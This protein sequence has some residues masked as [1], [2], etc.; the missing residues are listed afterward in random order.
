MSNV[1]MSGV[2][3]ISV[4]RIPREK[5]NLYGPEFLCFSDGFAAHYGKG[6][7]G[8]IVPPDQTAGSSRGVE[9]EFFAS[10]AVDNVGVVAAGD[11]IHR[12]SGPR[13]TNAQRRGGPGFDDRAYHPAIA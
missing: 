13:I 9:R 7:R 3:L 1:R 2:F 4:A 10:G 12:V 11:Y 6:Q 8:R 5:S